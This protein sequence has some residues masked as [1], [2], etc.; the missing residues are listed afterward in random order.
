[1]A[2]YRKA[3]RTNPI[4]TADVRVGLGLCLLKLGQKEKAELAFLRAL[5]MNP[6]CVTALV[7][8]AVHYMNMK[9]KE[10]TKRGVQ[11]LSRAYTIDATNPMTLNHLA[12]HFFFKKDFQKVRHL[13]LHAFHNTENEGMRAESCFQL[14]RSFH[15]Q[16]S[17]KK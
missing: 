15:I 9:S 2:F 10:A 11:L 16:V 3:L 14:A 5:E 4:S 6:K 1:M 12:N 7:G 17:L 13:A 8:M